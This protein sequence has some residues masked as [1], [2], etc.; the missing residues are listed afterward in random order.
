[1]ILAAQ[2]SPL[3]SQASASA[4]V[5]SP[6]LSPLSLAK[7]NPRH[8][9]VSQRQ[10]R[11]GLAPYDPDTLRAV[12]DEAVLALP[13]RPLVLRT[14]AAWSFARSGDS[15]PARLLPRTLVKTLGV[16]A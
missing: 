7:W 11:R 6:C 1:M 5:P 14:P 16:L 10:L 4:S 8:H 15:G 13:T 9:V 2:E 3:A 12:A